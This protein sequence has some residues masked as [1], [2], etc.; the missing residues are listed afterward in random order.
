MEGDIRINPQTQQVETLTPGG[1]WSAQ[2][3]EQQVGGIRQKVGEIGREVALIDSSR[4][5]KAIDKDIQDLTSFTVG[6]NIQ[7]QKG[8]ERIQISA[9]DFG[10]YAGM[11]YTAVPFETTAKDVGGVPTDLTPEALAA[12]SDGT[13]IP[14]TPEQKVIAAKQTEL[15]A[16][17]KQINDYIASLD[18]YR[19]KVSAESQGLI[20][21]I[22]VQSAARRN[23]MIEINQREKQTME[24]IGIRFGTQRYSPLL[25][26]DILSSVERAGMLKLA[27]L[28]ADEA[29]LIMEARKAQT[30]EEYK[31][32]HDKITLIKDLRDQKDKQLLEMQKEALKK[33]EETTKLKTQASR[34]LAIADLIGQ[35]ITDVPQLLNFL[36]YNESGK[37]IGDISVKEIGNVMDIV[38]KSSASS[39]ES[40]IDKFTDENGDRIN[41]F[42]NKN[43]G[44]LKQVKVGKEKI[45]GVGGGAV[46]GDAQRDAESIMRGDLSPN[47]LPTSGNYRATVSAI[48]SKKKQEALKKG[49][50]YG[51]MA[52]SAGGKDISDT[53]IL[54]M[55]KATNVVGQISDLQSLFK[56]DSALKEKTGVDLNPIIGIFRSKNPYD[57]KAQAI[58]AQL[59]SIVPNLARGVYGEVGVLTDNDIKI[60]SRTLPN[61][62]NTE[63]VR[64]MVLGLTIKSIQRSIENSIKVNAAAGRDV[65]GFKDVYT[66]VKE[67]SDNL[68][69]TPDYSQLKSQ[70]KKNEILVIDK[71]SGEIG[72]ILE[73]KF[74]NNLYEKLQ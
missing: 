21:S 69:G 35:G 46:S 5:E 59:S 31:I 22:K 54:A 60:Y 55:Q 44:E 51:I 64:N 33:S 63:D 36:N 18:V 7:V 65:S 49:D 11:G 6:G 66:S 40:V 37:L 16:A 42:Y 70:L 9:K 73:S 71:K 47:D 4:A 30:S 53:Q 28:D 48:V 12:V 68:I 3:V 17:N 15:D 2:A 34:D 74:D 8:A 52:A 1:I 58:K 39:D 10:K 14:Q 56:N 72:G 43:T 67:A 32:L 29:K 38:L 19:A 62:A 50:I 61:L 57:V 13:A 25:A 27:Q 26:M 45:T 41:V 20:D 24:T 23:A